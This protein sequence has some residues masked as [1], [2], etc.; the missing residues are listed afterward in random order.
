MSNIDPR[1]SALPGHAD[2]SADARPIL[3]WLED[4]ATAFA[5]R[6]AVEGI[7]RVGS[8]H[9]GLFQTV[10][11]NAEML[12]AAG[13][14][15]GDV[16]MIAL[17]NGPEALTAILSVAAVAVALP[18]SVDDPLA[19]AERV[20]SL[21][22]IR[23]VLFD[24]DRPGVFAEF[25]AHHDLEAL[26]VRIDPSAP[27]GQFQLPKTTRSHHAKMQATRPEDAAVLAKTAGTTAEPRLIA[28]SQTSL[29]RSA[30]VAAGWMGLDDEDRSLCV[31][32][33]ASLHSLVRSCMPGLLRG[34]SAICAPG[35]DKIRV[36]DWIEHCRPSYMTAVPGIYRMMLTRA[37]E[38]GTATAGTSL[39]FLAAGSDRLDLATVRSLYRAFGVPVREFYGM[40]EVAPMLAATPVGRLAQ[41]DGAIGPPLDH[42]TLTCR[43]DHGKPL[44]RG[45][46]GEL[47]AR[48]GLFNPVIA[49]EGRASGRIV[50]GWYLTGDRGFIDDAGL[51]H[52][53]G[54][55]DE[56]INRAGKKV[57]PEAV[58]AV[59]ATHPGVMRAAVF[60]IADPILGQRVAALV[61][62]ETGIDETALR[63]HCAKSLP[64]FM[65]PEHI[66]AVEEIPASDTGKLSRRLLAERFGAVLVRQPTTTG[67]GRR[68]PAN[69]S[70][71]TLVGLF[72]ELLGCDSIALEVGF[73]DQGG[74]SFLAVSLL[75]AVEE[76]FGILLSPADLLA[77]DS[78][79]GLARLI[80][81]RIDTD[82]TDPVVLVRQG[83]LGMP[84]IF[85]HAPMGYV[86]YAH[87][88]AQ[89]LDPEQPVYACQF[90][91]AVPES[92]PYDL[93]RHAAQ[94]VAAI[95]R[96]EPDGPYALI[97][98]SFAA[99]LA[100]EMAQ[101]LVA[102]GAA[103]PF[104]GLIDDEADL[105][106]RRFGVVR[107]RRSTGR[108]FAQ[109]KRLLA[110]YTP[111][112][113][114]GTADLFAAEV[115]MPETLADPL[116]GW[117]DLV[118]G[119]VT[120]HQVPGDHVT[121]MSEAEVARWA[122]L[123]RERLRVRAA[124]HAGH[125]T[126][127]THLDTAQRQV[128]EAAHQARRA[129]IA[130]DLDGEIAGYRAAVDAATS[131]LPYWIHRNLGLALLQRG[132]TES[133][134]RYLERAIAREATPLPGLTVLADAFG[135][136]GRP[137][138]ARAAIERAERM[139]PSCAQA[140]FL[141]GDLLARHGQPDRAETRLRASLVGEP[142]N[143]KA[144]A[145]LAA[146]LRALGRTEEAV[147]LARKAV[148]LR[149]Q[150][151][152][153]RLLLA[154][155]LLDVG[156]Q[157]AAEEMLRHVITLEPR[158]GVAHL[159]LADMLASRGRLLEARQS[160]LRAGE[161]L[162]GN[163]EVNR[164]LARLPPL[165]VETVGDSAPSAPTPN[166]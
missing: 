142:R 89:H 78:V 160:A 75:T 122:P 81:T 144:L 131:G 18:T 24:A 16:V 20:L 120:R 63:V 146:V 6:T 7:S 109:C 60:G 41:A 71:A 33:F 68:P 134:L 138:A 145:A 49:G 117:G 115:A 15:R 42:W 35:F 124:E 44:P 32:P 157:S 74:D 90:R 43:D 31:M 104:L 148:E 99:H 86:Y 52:L 106:K 136:L 165:P 110:A 98:H 28:W 123:L 129:A 17:P 161:L 77:D 46:E 128:L 51:L 95:R 118:L 27:A 87:S 36:F 121:M 62:A 137:E 8:T 73:M 59:L 135:R 53:T 61:V 151:A 45:A 132:E 12:L 147:P 105:F 114:P 79:V 108:T 9:A 103:V 112:S 143:A 92:E 91:R 38:A 5:G 84:L 47:A 159:R 39:R 149:P 155:L 83:S 69:H 64:D 50:D 152:G 23:A 13:I 72:R 102:S 26:P 141:L 125:P 127:G 70:E 80:E 166:P 119:G 94:Y 55:A 22:P 57:A 48:G 158:Q 85:A 156:D 93:E 30:D 154:D 163:A 19:E 11:A 101:Q 25:C 10:S 58:E 56:R 66:R 29:Y 162:P 37:E 67:R 21:I 164:L 54:R 97:G 34:G 116:V 140:Q 65:V 130:G 14:G 96:L 150:A 100:Y 40:N 88:I 113:Y 139:A 76:R 133:G 111:R 1:L 153:H 2:A 4:N 82:A 107:S 126:G 3:T